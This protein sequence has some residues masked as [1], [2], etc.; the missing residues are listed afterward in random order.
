M[1]RN[2]GNYIEPKIANTFTLGTRIDFS[3]KAL[4]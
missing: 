3:Y 1:N 4:S 2:I